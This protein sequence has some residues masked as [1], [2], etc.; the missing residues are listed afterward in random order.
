MNYGGRRERM[1]E[2]NVF[3]FPL[4][5]VSSGSC[6]GLVS[7]DCGGGRASKELSFRVSLPFDV[8]TDLPGAL[9]DGSDVLGLRGRDVGLAAED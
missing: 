6:G 4:H 5:L 2:S 8:G 9:V 1:R 7:S 3:A